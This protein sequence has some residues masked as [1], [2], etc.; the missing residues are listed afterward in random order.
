MPSAAQSPKPTRDGSSKELPSGI[1]ASRTPDQLFAQLSRN[2]AV[3]RMRMAIE[4]KL[5][6]SINERHSKT[7]KATEERLAMAVGRSDD[8]TESPALMKT[9]LDAVLGAASAEITREVEDLT[10]GSGRDWLS[11]IFFEEFERAWREVDER[12]APIISKPDKRPSRERLET[13]PTPNA[14]KTRDAL[15]GSIGA[16]RTK[17]TNASRARAGRGKKKGE[18]PVSRTM[19][20]K[21]LVAENENELLGGRGEMAEEDKS[22]LTKDTKKQRSKLGENSGKDMISGESKEQQRDQQSDPLSRE[23]RAPKPRRLSGED[24]KLGHSPEASTADIREGRIK[25]TANQQK[26]GRERPCVP[27]KENESE[28]GLAAQKNSTAGDNDAIDASEN[29]VKRNEHENDSEKEKQA[30]ITDS[31]SPAVNKEN[32]SDAVAA[33]GKNVEGNGSEKRRV[34]KKRKSHERG[35]S[36]HAEK[37][38]SSKPEQVASRKRPRTPEKWKKSRESNGDERTGSR[39]DMKTD[40]GMKE[41][42]LL[43]NLGSTTKSA[44]SAAT[45]EDILHPM[46]MNQDQSTPLSSRKKEHTDKAP[47]VQKDKHKQRGSAKHSAAR[48]S[49]DKMA[50]KPYRKRKMEQGEAKES[51]EPEEKNKAP[52]KRKRANESVARAP[53]GSCNKEDER[54][55]DPL[56]PKR[57]RGYQDN[58]ALCPPQDFAKQQK[59]LNALREVLAMTDADPFSQPVGPKDS[60]YAEYRKVI[61]NPMDLETIRNRLEQTKPEEGYYRSIRE[62]QEDINLVWWNCRRYNRTLDPIVG[63][64]ERCQQK[65]TMLLEKMNIRADENRQSRRRSSTRMGPSNETKLEPGKRATKVTQKITAKIVPKV[66][67]KITPKRAKSGAEK[68][69]E[70]HEGKADS[71]NLNDGQLVGRKGLIFKEIRNKKIW[72]SANV[73]AF[74]EKTSTYKIRWE[75]NNKIVKNISFGPN[76]TFPIHR[77]FR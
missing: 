29:A 30:K 54:N 5:A 70:K 73:L 16:S 2:G 6:D 66:V 50:M 57:P 45:D 26:D 34:L 3:Y 32:C 75:D 53:E 22:V 15:L 14:T 39:N 71:E 77:F 47:A 42:S 48:K 11:S 74:D 24:Q 52:K 58:R 76:G 37:K 36:E 43:I 4:K 72:S 56:D 8:T 69:S 31:A 18:L 46:R 21:V 60:F 64:A 7:A 1:Q 27:D 23:A 41:I 10:K 9:T 13:E 28:N 49:S 65:F 17:I 51:E 63:C 35:D 33:E 68:S 25:P 38:I 40:Q 59:I 19:E 67:P 55:W 20:K 62:I 12:P 61:P 44:S